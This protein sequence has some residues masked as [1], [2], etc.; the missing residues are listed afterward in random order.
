[1]NSILEGD[2]PSLFRAAR[3]ENSPIVYRGKYREFGVRVLNGPDGR[4]GEAI[5]LLA[6]CPFTGRQLPSSLRDLWFDRLEGLGYDPADGGIPEEYETEK[7]W[8]SEK[9]DDAA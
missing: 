3:D 2:F 5:D 9:Q 7:W 6:Y 4:P 1:M 8:S